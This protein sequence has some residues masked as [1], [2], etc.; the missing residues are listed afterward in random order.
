MR[1]TSFAVIGSD[2]RQRAAAAYLAR[3][4]YPVGGE[5]AAPGAGRFFFPRRVPT[6]S[7]CADMHRAAGGSHL[8]ARPPRR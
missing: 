7:C 6:R 8:W 2:A 5:E 1:Q 3:L 4:G